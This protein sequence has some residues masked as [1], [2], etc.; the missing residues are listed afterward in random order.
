MK[1]KDSKARMQMIFG[2]LLFAFIFMAELYA[3]VNFPKMFIVLAVLAAADLICLYVAIRGVISV[4]E[5]KYARRE[6]QYES[7]FKSEKASYLM[8]KKYFKEISVKLAY[9]EEA[10]KIPT[11]EI[12]NAQKGIAKV[13]IKR[14]HENTDALMNSYEQLLTGLIRSRKEWMG[15]VQL[16][17]LIRTRFFQPVRMKFLRCRRMEKNRNIHRIK[18]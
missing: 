12:V 17:V 6:E 7:I 10:S 1:N 9:M 2:I 16:R 11:E 15:S 3:I 5:T 8:L 4:Y 14:S 13:I 18:R